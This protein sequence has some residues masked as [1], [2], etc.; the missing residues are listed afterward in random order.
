MDISPE[1]IQFL[2]EQVALGVFQ[3][4]A[5]AIDEAISLLRDRQQLDSV[6]AAINQLDAKLLEGVNSPKSEM[7][8]E[9]WQRLEARAKARSRAPDESP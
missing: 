3:N 9:D 2:D 8:G 6:V 5:E 4:R 1:S 7:T